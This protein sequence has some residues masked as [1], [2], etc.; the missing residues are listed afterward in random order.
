LS[1]IDLQLARGF[2]KALGLFRSE[3]PSEERDRRLRFLL[4]VLPRSFRLYHM[5]GIHCESTGASAEA[6]LVLERAIEVD[7]QSA[8]AH[9]ALAV[10]LASLR[11]TVEA[12]EHLERAVALRPEYAEAHHNLGCALSTVGRTGE[13]MDHFRQAAAL[14]PGSAEMHFNLGTAY[15]HL[16]KLGEARGALE[17]AID[18]DPRP[19]Y[20]FALT[21]CGRL[22]PGSP[23]AEQLLLLEKNSASL[24]AEE[25]IKVHFALGNLLRDQGRHGLAFAQWSRGNALKRSLLHYDEAATLG[26]VG[27]IEA[28][29]TRDVIRKHADRG[30]PSTLPVFI[31]GMPRSGTTLVEQVLASHP[32]VFGAGEV[33][34]LGRLPTRREGSEPC[35]PEGY[36]S[37][38]PERLRALGADCIGRLRAFGPAAAERIVDKMPTNFWFLGL[39]HMAMPHARIIHVRRD[40]LDTCVSCYSKLFGESP[41]LFAYD[42]GELGRY[43]RAYETVMEHWRR[44]LPQGALLEV[45]Y[46]D[47]VANLETQARRITTFC[48]LRWDPACL[49]FHANGRY[50]ATASSTQV[51]R[52]IYTT[53]IGG[54]RPYREFLGPLAAGLGTSLPAAE[55]PGG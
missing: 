52:P 29:F 33:G 7:P 47:V 6:V 50:V 35:Y 21:E 32:A 46:E 22:E 51:R 40:P 23:R 24:P 25:R 38:G 48:G 30:D 10:S 4:R 5:F 11:R 36:A 27:R 53:A 49:A 1:S 2:A 42:L 45:E 54:W 41:P 39:I 12:I 34:S 28:S 16:G 20:F 9:N 31:V 37:M 19:S 14:K 55:P 44:V 3:L 18:L 26:L 17:R 13:A 15:L 43:Y 8:E